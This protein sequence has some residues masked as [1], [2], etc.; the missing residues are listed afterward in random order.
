M[1]AAFENL[2]PA[3][4]ALVAEHT[5]RTIDRMVLFVRRPR[6]LQLRDLTDLQGYCYAVAGIVGE[7]LTELFLLE[8]PELATV[9]ADLRVGAAQFGEALQLANILKDSESDVDE[10]RRYLPP[11]VERAEVFELARDDLERAGEYVRLLQGQDAPRGIVAFTALPVLLARRTLDRVEQ[12]GPGSKLTRPEV[13]EI[14]GTLDAALASGR[15]V[16]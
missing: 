5:R 12:R 9:A 10:G 6:P 3:A 8:R 7:M 15:P 13:A 14:V 2:T 1:L 4:R 11:G 16:A